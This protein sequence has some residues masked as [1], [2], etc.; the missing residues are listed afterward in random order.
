MPRGTRG[1]VG[2]V[3]KK[4][5]AKDLFVAGGTNIALLPGS[6]SEPENVAIRS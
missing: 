6:I 1:K 4:E 2:G 3:R 5:A